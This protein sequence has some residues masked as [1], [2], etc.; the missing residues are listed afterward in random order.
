MRIRFSNPSDV[1]ALLADRDL[2]PQVVFER[3][4]DDE[5][6]AS[7]LGSFRADAMMMNLELTLRAW[8]AARRAE[9]ANITFEIR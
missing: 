4:A 8:A 6:E 2:Y 5:V 3:V 9:G 7:M 1:D